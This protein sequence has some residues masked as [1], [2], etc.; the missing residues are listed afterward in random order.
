MKILERLAR[1][2]AG[3]TVAFEQWVT[4]ATLNLSWG[5]TIF[6]IT[7]RGE[8]KTC[9]IVHRLV[10]AGY[11]PFLFVMEPDYNFSQVRERARRLGFRAFNVSGV[12]DLEQWQAQPTR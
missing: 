10:K 1:I 5:V 9:Q 7:A 12:H 3:N 6:V 2:G 8:E 4:T 11:N